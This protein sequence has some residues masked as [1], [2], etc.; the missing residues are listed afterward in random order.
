MTS[1]K[2]SSSQ[3]FPPEDLPENKT[4]TETGTEFSD[5]DADATQPLSPLAAGYQYVEGDDVIAEGAEDSPSEDASLG[6]S[7]LSRG[8]V[9]EKRTLRERVADRAEARAAAAEQA[10]RE[11]QEREEAIARAEARQAA[12][13]SVPALPLGAKTSE[14]E[15]TRGS[16]GKLLAASLAAL[17]VLG[18]ATATGMMLGNNG[19]NPG[20]VPAAVESSATSTSASP[21]ASPTRTPESTR[22]TFIPEITETDIPVPVYVEPTYAPEPAY[23]PAPVEAPPIAPEPPVTT[24]EA[25]VEPTTTE[26]PE[27]AD[28]PTTDELRTSTPI[29]SQMPDPA[30]IQTPPGATQPTTET[31]TVPDPNSNSGQ[32]NT[33]ELNQVAPANG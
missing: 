23:V 28:T 10:K 18:V 21:G 31:Q 32:N 12:A 9:I 2:K 6:L 16:R 33:P 8:E 7:L 19:R 17:M 14:H 3:D 20:V 15:D 11:K 5:V 4:G 13:Q 22:T 29:I 30:H 1:S 24:S 26:A 27:A 25:T